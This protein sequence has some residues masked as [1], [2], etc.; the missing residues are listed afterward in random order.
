MVAPVGFRSAFQRPLGS[1]DTSGSGARRSTGPTTTSG[2]RRAPCDPRSPSTTGATTRKM[3]RRSATPTSTRWSGSCAA[4]RSSSPSWSTTDSPTQQVGAPP[5]ATF[6][7]VRHRVPMMSLDNAFSPDELVAWG[8]RLERRLAKEERR[9]LGEDDDE[10]RTQRSAVGTAASS[11]STASPSRCATRTASWCRARPVATGAPARTSPPT[12]APSATIPKRLQKGAPR[13]ARGARRGL[14]VRVRAFDG[15]P[16]APAERELAG[17]RPA[18]SPAGRRQ[19]P[20]R[21][22]RLA[23]PE[24]RLGH[25]QPRAVDVVLPARRGGGRPGVHHATSETLDFLADL[26]LPGEPRDPACSTPSRRCT[27]SAPTGRSTATTSTTRSTASVVKV[28]DLGR[29]EAARVHVPGAALGDRLQVPARGAHH[30]A[31]ATSR[32]RSAA[33]AASPPSP[34]SSRCSSAGPTCPGHPPQPGPGEGQGRAGRRHR[35]RPP[36]RRRHPRGGRPGAWP[37]RPRRPAAV[38]VPDALP[39]PRRRARW[40]GP[41]A[42]ATPAASTPSARSSRPAHIEHFASRGAM[43][44]EGF[45]EQRV[46]LFLDLGL[47]ADVGRHLRHRLGPAGALRTRSATGPPR[48]SPPPRSGGRPAGQARRGDEA[49]IPPGSPHALRSSRTSWPTTSLATAGEQGHRRRPARAR[50]G[51]RRQAAAAI[52]ATKERPLASLLVG[53][54][55]RHLGP[56]GSLGPGPGVRPPGPHRGRRRR[57]DGHRGPLPRPPAACSSPS[58]FPTSTPPWPSTASSSAPSRTSAARATPTSRSAS[59]RSSSC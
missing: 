37:T 25:R 30:R 39:V 45:G 24:G 19:P 3:R 2:P 53:L 58:T 33:P 21:R 22:R 28:D 7:P 11:R 27:R 44:I 46:R 1:S 32:C 8:E 34:S 41:R 31:A 23:A 12:S 14:H 17:S 26:G 4:S 52:A 55:I 5:S 54:N 13:G 38:G 9:A 48:R 49:D 50:R 16:G 57:G 56:S 20:Q 59:R 36:G 6:A 47:I 35:H 15:A 29:R 51:S 18:A 10:E 40:S 42:R 43:D